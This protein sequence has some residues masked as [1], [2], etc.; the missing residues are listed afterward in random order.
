MYTQGLSDV[1]YD[2]V[3]NRLERLLGDS[4]PAR[5]L[6]FGVM[7]RLFLRAR[8]IRREINRL[9][10]SGFKPASVLDAGSGFGQYS[11]RLARA[12]P[13]AQ[14][15]GLDLKKDLVESGNRFAQRM[16]LE[17]VTFEAGDLLAMDYDNRFDLALSVDVL[18]HIEDDRRVIGNIGRVLKQNGLFIFTTPYYDGKDPDSA[19]FV[20]EHVRP[21]YSREE[22]EEK[23]SEAGFRLETFTI[24]YGPWGGAAWTLLQKWPMTWLSGRL[25]LLPLVFIYYLITYPVSWLFMHI[26][27]RIKNTRGGGILAIAVKR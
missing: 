3:K 11:Y 2:A 6:F 1:E 8:Y 10:K 5:K 13:G 18:E 7:D 26:D 21:G 16:R 19:V 4:V 17:N 23:L 24:T 22:T 12:F 20:D 15:A 9:R 27:M 25:W 14:I